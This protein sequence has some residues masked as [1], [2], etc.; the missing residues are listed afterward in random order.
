[1]GFFFF[2]KFTARG[3]YLKTIIIYNYTRVLRVRVFYAYL[4]YWNTR[5]VDIWKKK[6]EA[7]K[8]Y[9]CITTVVKKKK[10]KKS[11]IRRLIIITLKYILIDIYR[12]VDKI[13]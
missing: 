7:V 9:P 8:K 12:G 5:L 3:L 11:R 13:I 10:N 1:M 4:S 2:I 6:Q